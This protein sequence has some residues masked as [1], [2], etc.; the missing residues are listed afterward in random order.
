MVIPNI[1]DSFNLYSSW[2]P[3][4]LLRLKLINVVFAGNIY[5]QGGGGARDQPAEQH[6]HQ[7]GGLRDPDRGGAHQARPAPP[8]RPAQAA[9]DHGDHPGRSGQARQQGSQGGQHEGAG[10]SSL[11]TEYHGPGHD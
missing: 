1:K 8:A 2:D 4:T 7:P 3:W 9:G 11:Q 5:Q 6:H 10:A